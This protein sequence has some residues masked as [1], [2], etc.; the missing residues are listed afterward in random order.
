MTEELKVESSGLRRRK[1]RK[2]F[3][4][5]RRFEYI[6]HQMGDNSS[7]DKHK[8]VCK[9][10]IKV[11]EE[12]SSCRKNAVFPLKPPFNLA[13]CIFLQFSIKSF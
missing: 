13:Q 8:D 9:R 4:E 2:H 3:E 7:P 1:N 10:N 5:S 6:S 11:G 12:I